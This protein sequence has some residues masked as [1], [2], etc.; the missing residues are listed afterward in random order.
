MSTF[1]TTIEKERLMFHLHF[2]L[3]APDLCPHFS[4]FEESSCLSFILERMPAKAHICPKASAVRISY[5][6]V[7]NQAPV[8]FMSQLNSMDLNLFKLQLETQIS[9]ATAI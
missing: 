6:Q 7:T 4:G 5:H 3:N 2:G 1:H 9:S 8:V